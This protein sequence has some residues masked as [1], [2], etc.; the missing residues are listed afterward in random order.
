MK[1]IVTVLFLLAFSIPSFSEVYFPKGT[2]F[3]PFP[4]STSN[5]ALIE[6]VWRG[7]SIDIKIDASDYLFRGRPILWVEIQDHKENTSRKGVIYYS[8]QDER[9]QLF[10]QDANEGIPISLE[11]FEFSSAYASEAGMSCK[12]GG[13][14]LKIE[15]K[16]STVLGEVLLT[17]ESCS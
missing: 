15:F 13:T 12:S 16:I 5:V 9:Y 11:I 14:L 8:E 3:A 6:G 7:E 4:L 1:K 2:D 17:K 10:A